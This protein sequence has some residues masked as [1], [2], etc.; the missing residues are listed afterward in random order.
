MLLQYLNIPFILITLLVKDISVTW[1]VSKELKSN[2]FK[3]IQSWNIYDISLT[4][5]VLKSDKS[6]L[7]KLSHPEN[8]CDKLFTCCVSINCIFNILIKSLHL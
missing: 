2:K 6:K 8:I 3:D 7:S 4:W 5:P 1:E